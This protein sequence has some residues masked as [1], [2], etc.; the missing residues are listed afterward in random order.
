MDCGRLS[1]SYCVI[2]RR[3]LLLVFLGKLATYVYPG[4]EADG[5]MWWEC[6][7]SRVTGMLTRV[8]EAR[9]VL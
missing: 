9:G 6:I 5:H 2:Q 3:L 1:P 4:V 8:I 7:V